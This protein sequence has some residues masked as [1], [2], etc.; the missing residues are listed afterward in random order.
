MKSSS[1]TG[2]QHLG[3]LWMLRLDKPLPGSPQPR[4]PVTFSCAGL[5]EAAELAS[6]MGLD[7]PDTVLQRF[8]RGS[9]C[10]I[11]RADAR[12]V[13]YGWVSFGEEEIGELALHIRLNQGEA[14]IWDCGTL[15]AYRGKRLYPALLG[16]ML[17]ELKNA[18]FRRVW[19]GTDA[20]NLPSQVGVA[21]V[22]CQPVL[23]VV[24][25]SSSHG[26]VSRRRPGVPIE[27][28]VDAHYAMFG[29]RDVTQIILPEISE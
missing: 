6:A 20:D 26:L 11:V 27:D 5:G 1:E 24:R 8:H 23:D 25:D 10:Y 7:N 22:G 21:L 2:V 9:R 13:A 28:A 17:C 18:G 12:I 15:P 3:I 14:Y 4:I 19:I 29:N 16:Y